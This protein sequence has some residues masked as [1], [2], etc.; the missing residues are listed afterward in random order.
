MESVNGRLE[1]GPAENLLRH[2]LQTIL[3][4]YA[5]IGNDVLFRNLLLLHEDESLGFVS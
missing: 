3:K 2:A 4:T 1:A 5:N